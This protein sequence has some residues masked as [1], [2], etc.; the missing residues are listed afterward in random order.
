MSEIRKFDWDPVGYSMWMKNLERS[1]AAERYGKKYTQKIVPVKNLSKDPG[2]KR[3][4]WI[5]DDCAAKNNVIDPE[6]MK[7]FTHGRHMDIRW[8]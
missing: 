1:A 2:M 4:I 7:I 8:F 3:P 5:N 6:L